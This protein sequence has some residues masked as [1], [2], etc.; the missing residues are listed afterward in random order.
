MDQLS[1][2]WHGH[3][4]FSL[5]LKDYTVVFDPYEDGSVPGLAPLRLSANLVLCSHNHADHNAVSVVRPV[6][7][8]KNPF[9]IRTVETYHDGEQ[10][11]LRGKNLIHILESR[12]LRIAHFGDVGCPLTP[13]QQ[14]EVGKLDVAMIPVGGF[15][16]IEPAQAKAMMDLLMPKIVLPMHYRTKDFGY[17][18]LAT[19]DDFMA[20]IG[21]CV[22]YAGN[23]I[24]INQGTKPQIA[25]LTY[26]G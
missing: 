18:Q 5:T 22:Y 1:L 7:G 6:P 2:V 14:A 17:P 24:L 16:T 20:L 21:D 9:R 26:P 15:F 8:G 25:V 11:R 10:G 3:S 4:C 13:L 12:D 19:L 23:T